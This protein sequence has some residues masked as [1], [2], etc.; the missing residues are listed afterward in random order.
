MENINTIRQVFSEYWSVRAP[1]YS[2]EM[3]S[4]DKRDEWKAELQK[5]VESCH[6]QKRPGE[7]KV[8]ELATGHGY[9]AAIFAELG[10]SVTAVDMAPGMLEEA[11]KNCIQFADSISFMEMNAEELSFADGSFDVVFSRYL[12][13]L[14]PRPEKAYS[15]WTR[16]LKPSGLMLTYDTMQMK[17]RKNISEEKEESDSRA[18]LLEKTG[19]KAEIYDSLINMSNEFEIGYLK[20]P[21]WDVTV[22]TKLGVDAYSEDVTRLSALKVKPE[23]DAAEDKEPVMSPLILV[24]GIKK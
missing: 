6:P 20:R 22:L 15:E 21:E 23:E 12:T 8:L 11:R 10:Y 13:W 24:K 5:R 3:R 16:V 7:I 14:L 1:S 17:E 18:K 2:E 19:M 4:I 9:F